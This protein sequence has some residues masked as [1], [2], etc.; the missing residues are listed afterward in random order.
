VS[1][2]I[3]RL[4]RLLSHPNP[5][6]RKQTVQELGKFH[7]PE[8]TD[9]LI[10]F[11][12]DVDDFVRLEAVKMLGESMDQRAAQP[13]KDLYFWAMHQES[14]RSFPLGFHEFVLTALKKLGWELGMGGFQITLKH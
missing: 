3:L 1:T 2:A 14:E 4:A 12:K 10:G 13:L 8:A 5:E 11:L 6:V 9:A 7:T